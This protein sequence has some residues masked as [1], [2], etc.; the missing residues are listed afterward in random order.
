MR[1]VEAVGWDWESDGHVKGTRRDLD[2]TPIQ[3]EWEAGVDRLRDV[4]AARSTEDRWSG[5]ERNQ[6]G[7]MGIMKSSS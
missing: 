6:V 4:E 5:R 7:R 1:S 3:S 2:T